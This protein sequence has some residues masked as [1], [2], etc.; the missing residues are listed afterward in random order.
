MK[1]TKGKSKNSAISVQK[2]L[3]ITEIHDDTVVLKNGGIRS[4]LEIKPV[5]FNL[6]SEEEQ[7][8]IIYGYQKFLNSLN[9]PIQILI[10]SRK[11][12]IDK[13]LDSLIEKQRKQTNKM[14]AIQM[15][16]HIDYID[17]LV[18]YADIM[19]KR[20]YI[21]VSMEFNKSDERKSS[22]ASF[23]DK[24][25]P[26]DTILDIVKRKKAFANLKKD[27][28][29]RVN[30]VKTGLG[31]CGVAIE[32]L[33]TEKLIT[34]FYQSYNDNLSHMQKMNKPQDTAVDGNAGDYLVASN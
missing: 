31:S 22:W 9:F 30:M 17:E 21:I 20:F 5:N 23:L 24:I 12:D 11:L 18:K 4:V 7:N 15:L 14:L 3:S 2:Y 6:K 27:L 28:D 34:L 16:E 33:K 13:Y 32:Q 1:T 26:S 29:A 19:D 25:K 8:S 10:K